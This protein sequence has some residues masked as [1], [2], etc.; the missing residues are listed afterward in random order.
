MTIQVTY[1][2]WSAKTFNVR[3]WEIYRDWILIGVRP[4]VLIALVILLSKSR[5]FFV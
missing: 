2:S 4:T 1:Q 5:P 3:F